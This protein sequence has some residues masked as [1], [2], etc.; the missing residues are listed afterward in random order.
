MIEF[1]EIEGKPDVKTLAEIE[2]FYASI[3]EQVEPGKF[4]KRISEAFN[5][6][7]VL[8]LHQDKIVG[9]KVGFQIAPKKF[10]SW[11]G[12]VSEDFR[13]QGIAAELMKRQHDWCVRNGFEVVRTKTK[14]CFKSMLILNIKNSFDVVEV[15]QDAKNERKI[16]LEK[17]LL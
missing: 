14:N 1:A 10:Y 7:T 8:A 4:E 13:K 15:Y 3:F 6:L 17:S 16:I 12:G 5:L 9:F 11:I 2:K